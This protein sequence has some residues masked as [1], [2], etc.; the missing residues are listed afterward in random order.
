MVTSALRPHDDVAG[1]PGSSWS[2]FQALSLEGGLNGVSRAVGTAALLDT[3]FAV[4]QIFFELVLI[5]LHQV[6]DRALEL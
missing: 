3:N 1:Q 2:C 6:K 5:Q 4:R